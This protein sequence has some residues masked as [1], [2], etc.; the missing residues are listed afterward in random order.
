LSSLVAS[1]MGPTAES[2]C[3]ISWQ[4]LVTMFSMVWL[5]GMVS[6]AWVGGGVVSS[7]MGGG[8]WG[9]LG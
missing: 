7:M 2:I 3:S 4:V 8:G 6:G 5:V 9:H 1:T